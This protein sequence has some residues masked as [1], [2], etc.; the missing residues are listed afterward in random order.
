LIRLAVRTAQSHGCDKFLAHVQAQNEVL[1][2]RLHWRSLEEV[3]L[4]GVKH[5]KMQADL[6]YYPPLTD[7]PAGWY[8]P[9]RRGRAA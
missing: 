5:V 1:F 8:H 3:T 2:R 4:R 9:T 6:G 7:A